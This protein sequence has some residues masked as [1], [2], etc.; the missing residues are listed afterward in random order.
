MIHALADVQSSFIG[1]NTFVWQFSVI[2]KNA[3]IGDNCNINCH[4]FIEN[5]VLIGDNVT[6]KSGN[7]L[8]DGLLVEDNVFIGPN[9]TFTNDRKPRSKQYPVDFQKTSIRKNAS[10]G[11]GS[12]IVGGIEI[13]AYAMVG[14][15]SLVTKDVPERALVYGSPASIK[16][17]LNEDGSKMKSEGLYFIDESGRK[18]KETDNKLI[19]L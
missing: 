12:I 1:K 16:G 10:I 7:Y 5:K 11:A 2:L 8:W 15:G 6:V 4:V 3:I 13:G 19:L 9:V 17:W 18:W 14:A